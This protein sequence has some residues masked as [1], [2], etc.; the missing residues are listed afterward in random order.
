MR[1]DILNTV[2]ERLTVK[3]QNWLCVITGETG[4][5][6]SW[7]AL[8][9]GA[10]LDE[11]FNIDKVAFEP[12]DII[13]LIGTS[14]HGD[15]IVMD[16]AGISFGAR[17]FMSKHNRALGNIFQSFRYKQIGLIWTL[18]DASM[19][20]VQARRLMHTFLE[21]MPIDY[22]RGLTRVKWFDIYTDKWTG[23]YRHRY[24]RVN[25]PKYGQVVVKVVKF[26]KPPSYIT[27]DYQIKKDEAF[28]HLLEESSEILKDAKKTK[29][30]T[31][32]VIK[33]VDTT[34]I[35]NPNIK[36]DPIMALYAKMAQKKKVS[37]ED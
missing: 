16:E 18:P 36:G 37:L 28:M 1:Y 11:N 26:P 30:K 6:K 8:K 24:P 3:N 21:T 15:I 10:L 32:R 23:E 17:S 12:V 4:S 9:I 13:P 19:I 27:D 20:D 35:D 5:G 31:E 34:P 14:E 7:T 25:I 29:K 22:E 2:R 33:T